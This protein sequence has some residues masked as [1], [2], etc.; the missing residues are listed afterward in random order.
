MERGQSFSINSGITGIDWPPIPRPQAALPLAMLFQLQQTEWLS[1]EAL[2]QQQRRQ[3]H[4]VLTHALESVPFYREGWG[5]AGVKAEAALDPVAWSQMPTLTRR[6]LQF[7]GEGL[8]S[9]ALPREHG[10]VSLHVTGGSTG[11]PVRVL[12]TAVTSA[13]WRV[14]TLRDHLWHRRDFSG[15]LAAI[16]FVDSEAARPPAGAKAQ[17][18]GSAT[19]GLFE[20][21]PCSLLHINS[22]T[23]E[24]ACWLLQEDPEYLM[25]YP[26]VVH[27]LARHFE[28]E[29]LKLNRLREVRSFGEILE[30][31]VREACRR[32]WNVPVVDTYSSEEFGYLALQCPEHDCY[33]IQAENVLLEVLDDDGRACKPGEIGRVVVTGLHNFAM[34]LIRYEIGDYA[35]VGEPCACG[36]GLP[37]L[38]RVLG[39]QR[40]MF[41][42]PDGRTR[43][44]VVEARD[45][46]GVFEDLPPITKFQVVQKTLELLELNL[47]TLRPLT[48]K[49]EEAIRSYVKRGLEYDFDVQFNYVEDIPRTPRG[50]YEEFRS[51]VSSAS[52]G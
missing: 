18:W 25:T 12:G 2:Q 46:A 31:H 30:P 36:R 35:E 13:S 41:T 8:H 33:H 7:A 32:A 9:T 43:W 3:L 19:R 10:K 49:E 45:L 47:V 5:G 15:K 22:T 24:Q 51:E 29:G 37:V 11:E 28:R 21:G 23:D 40:N 44:P 6:E 1:T 14:F 27:A 42:M 50:K 26:T 39:R 16:R 34:P 17:N 4:R 38:R 20:T 48:P 52:N